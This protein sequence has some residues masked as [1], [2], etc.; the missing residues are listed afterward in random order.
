MPH[1]FLSY[2]R[3]LLKLLQCLSVWWRRTGSWNILPSIHTWACVLSTKLKMFQTFKEADDCDAASCNS[4][5]FRRARLSVL[6]D[7]LPHWPRRFLSA[8]SFQRIGIAATFYIHIINLIGFHDI[9]SGDY[10][11]S[12]S[13]RFH[14]PPT[15]YLPQCPH[16]QRKRVDFSSSPSTN[17][18]SINSVGG[19][20]S[21]GNAGDDS[22]PLTVLAVSPLLTALAVFPPLAV[23]PLMVHSANVLFWILPRHQNRR[24]MSFPLT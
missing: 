13:Y 4:L 9:E 24:Q 19:G 2:F 10:S 12:S 5:W 7:P 18:D 6:L 20:S 16:I 15:G 14:L 11:T 17:G 3:G 23:A 22:S 21:I 1:T 8:S